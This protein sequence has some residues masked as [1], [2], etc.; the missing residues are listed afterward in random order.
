M[1]KRRLLTGV[2]TTAAL[3]ALV[4]GATLSLFTDTAENNSNTFT[5]G[6]VDIDQVSTFTCS[7]EADNL[8]P[9]DS[10]TCTVEVTYEGTLDAWLGVT[11]STSGDLFGGANPLRVDLP[12]GVDVDGI[13]VL[14]QVSEG[15]TVVIEV[16]WE[17][18]LEAG[19]EYQGK[20]GQV[21]LTVYAVQARNNTRNDGSG[22]ISWN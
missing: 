12:A 17:F 2:V 3:S 7:V 10:G 14:G 6:T 16:D 11:A 20:N 18:P 9:G 1:S 15:D 22:P 4:T 13:R 5:A 21:D 19:N 8:A